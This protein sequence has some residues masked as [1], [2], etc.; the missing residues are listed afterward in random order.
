MT[1]ELWTMQLTLNLNKNFERFFEKFLKDLNSIWK[2]D[3]L[4]FCCV[5]KR[6]STAYVQGLDYESFAFFLL[7]STNPN[8]VC[9][10]WTTRNPSLRKGQRVPIKYP[11]QWFFTNPSHG[12]FGNFFHWV[13]MQ[14]IG[15]VCRVWKCYEKSHEKKPF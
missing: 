10:F 12:G 1:S 11:L 8:P 9:V 3:S 7:I 13:P 6:L 2:E 4:E 15:I 5:V 14:E